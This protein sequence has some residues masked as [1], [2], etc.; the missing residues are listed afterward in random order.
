[1]M[2]LHRWMGGPMGYWKCRMK[3]KNGDLGVI[4]NHHCHQIATT[5]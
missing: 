5:Y 4:H 2:A 1:M 3:A